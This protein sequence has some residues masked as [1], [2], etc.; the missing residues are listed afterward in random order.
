MVWGRGG[1]GVGAGVFAT[2]LARRTD[3]GGAGAAGGAIGADAGETEA[4][5]EDLSMTFFIILR[6]L[7]ALF[8]STRPSLAVG[9]PWSLILVPKLLLLVLGESK[10]DV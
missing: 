4:P 9:I 8:V 5:L 10:L 1:L 7:A 2:G 3:W 6:S